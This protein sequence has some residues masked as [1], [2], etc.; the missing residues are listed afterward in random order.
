MFVKLREFIEK[1]YT[2][3]LH[4][5]KLVWTKR[6]RI[7]CDG[8][9]PIWRWFPKFYRATY[10]PYWNLYGFVMY[11]FGR[12]INFVFGEDINKLYD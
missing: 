12:E 11:L 9:Q 3:P 7:F 8:G 4:A 6:V 5:K 2:H 10:H 1:N